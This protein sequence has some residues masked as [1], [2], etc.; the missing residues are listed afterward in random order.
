[1]TVVVAFLCSDGV[2]IAADSM[3]TPSVGT[4]ATGHHT[5]RKIHLVAGPQIVAFSG[6]IGIA[7]RFRIAADARAGQIA[8]IAHALDHGLQISNAMFTQLQ[9]TGIWPNVDIGLV[10]AYMHGGQPHCCVFLNRVQPWLLDADHFY[11]ALG[12]GKLSADP[13]LRFLTDIFCEPGQ[14][15]TVR[16]AVFLANW[17]VQHVIDTTPGGVAGPIRIAVFERDNAGAFVARELPDT[18]I[19]E[20]KQ[21]TESA[22]DALRNWRQNIQSGAAAQGVPQPPP[23]PAAPPAGPG[24]AAPPGPTPP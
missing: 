23:A 15:P 20:H 9:A 7:A 16:E 13:F 3:L 12:S 6:D 11:A 18:E 8:G 1:M 5:G 10:L 24:A 14:P 4:V 17:T 2:V 19:D 22:A 21:A